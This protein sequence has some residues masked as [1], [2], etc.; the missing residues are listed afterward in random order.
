MINL[1]GQLRPIIPKGIVR[2][3][4]QMDYHVVTFNVT[5]FNVTDIFR[6]RRYVIYVAE[7]RTGPKQI[8][9]Q[10]GYIHSFFDQHLVNKVYAVIAPMI[11]GGDA[12]SAVVGRGAERMK[13]VVRLRQMSVE[14][15]GDDILVTG[16]PV[17][18][19][20]LRCERAG[21]DWMQR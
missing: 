7:E 20:R 4:G 1:I 19:P 10:T 17:G 13:D 14:R 2:Q 6:Y 12:V 9:I 18:I 8:R 21:P 11:I 5:F 3:T 16:Y 15:L